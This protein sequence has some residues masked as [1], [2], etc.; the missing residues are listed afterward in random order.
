MRLE[1]LCRLELAY[2]PEVFGRHV[3]LV[4]P[5][6]EGEAYAYGEGDGRASGERLSG[7]VRWSNHPRRRSDGVFLP[8]VHGVVHTED[9]AD[10]IF[11]LSGRTTQL[12]EGVGVQHLH[13]TFHADDDAHRWL[14]DVVCVAEGRIHVE[15]M[16]SDIS[17]YYC[18]NE[19]VGR[20]GSD[21]T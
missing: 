20:T 19:G 16:R 3:V 5:Y 18:V 12:G 7:S 8:D 10:V 9:G 15:E 13:A 14:N 4:A 11:S 1:P 21:R 17:V 6:G 2:T